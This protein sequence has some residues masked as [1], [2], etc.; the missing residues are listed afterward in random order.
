SCHVSSTWCQYAGACQLCCC[1]VVHPS[2]NH[3]SGRWY[4][5]SSMNSSHSLLVTGRD[6]S[7]NGYSHTWWRGPSLSKANPHSSC[8][9]SSSPP[10]WCTQSCGVAAAGDGVVIGA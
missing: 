5:P 8:P 9:I 3:S 2:D 1:T 6:A 7:A 4:P 10:G